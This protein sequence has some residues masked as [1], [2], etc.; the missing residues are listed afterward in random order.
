L[1]VDLKAIKE[2]MKKI[3]EKRPH[4]TPEDNNKCLSNVQKNQNIP[5][6]VVHA[7]TPSTWEAEA[8]G[9]LSSRSAWSTK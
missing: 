7:F 4:C 3:E 8:G 9:F 5:G 1:T 6:V 2:D